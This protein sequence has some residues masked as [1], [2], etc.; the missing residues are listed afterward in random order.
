MSRLPPDVT[1]AP[2][3]WIWT[4]LSAS[5]PP[6]RLFPNC[7]T[8]SP[9]C[10]SDQRLW[11]KISLRRLSFRRSVSKSRLVRI[12]GLLVRHVRAQRRPSRSAARRLL[13]D[14]ALLYWQDSGNSRGSYAG[15][16]SIQHPPPVLDGSLGA[17]NRTCS[18]ATRF[19]QLHC[20]SRLLAREACPRCLLQP[21]RAPRLPSSAVQ[22]VAL[23]APPA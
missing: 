22:D 4:T 5:S 13:H 18:R 20:P 2:H 7:A 9:T 1:S 19:D 3:S 10:S 21:S 6:F 12:L 23:S 15:L 17:A 8:K 16:H 11:K 14:Q